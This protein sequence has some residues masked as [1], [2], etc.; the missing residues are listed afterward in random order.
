MSRCACASGTDLWVP[1]N[2]RTLCD[3]LIFVEQPTE[4]IVS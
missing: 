3:V 1:E 4:P 2:R